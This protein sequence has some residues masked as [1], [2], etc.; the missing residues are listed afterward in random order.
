M[1]LWKGLEPPPMICWAS[2]WHVFRQGV[3]VSGT[4]INTGEALWCLSACRDCSPAPWALAEGW[5]R[6]AHRPAPL[7]HSLAWSPVGISTRPVLSS[8]RFLSGCDAGRLPVS[9]G[10]HSRPRPLPACL[11][12]LARLWGQLSPTVSSVPARVCL[13]A[14]SC[15]GLGGQ[16]PGGPGEAAAGWGWLPVRVEGFVEE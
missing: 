2:A 4:V 12:T 13:L 3:V 5:E 15:P 6:A 1:L 7:S 14:L 16:L 8:P 9:A 10:G 11:V